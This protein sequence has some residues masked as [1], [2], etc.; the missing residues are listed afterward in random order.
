MKTIEDFL[1]QPVSFILPDSRVLTGVLG[2]DG[3]QNFGFQNGFGVPAALIEE[4]R[5]IEAPVE[6]NLIRA[7][8]TIKQQ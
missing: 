8:F 5:E 1:G 3:Q 2:T 6:V 7:V 4:V